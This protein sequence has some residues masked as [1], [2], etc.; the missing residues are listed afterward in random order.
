MKHFDPT[1]ESGKTYRTAGGHTM[2]VKIVIA[3][4]HRP[5]LCGQ[6]Q[7]V[8]GN[9]ATGSLVTILYN[10]D[11]TPKGTGWSAYQLLPGAIEDEKPTFEVGKSYRTRKGDVVKI[12]RLT[13]SVDYPL[14]GEHHNQSWTLD[15]RYW[16]DAKQECSADLMPGA[17]EDEPAVDPLCVLQAQINHIDLTLQNAMES[18]T[19]QANDLRRQLLNVRGSVSELTR[20]LTSARVNMADGLGQNDER[21]DNLEKHCEAMQTRIEDQ[22]KHQI[23]LYRH[24]GKLEV[25]AVCNPIINEDFEK[26]LDLV[27][28]FMRGPMSAQTTRVLEMQGRIANLEGM[29]A[30]TAATI[31]AAA[32]GKRDACIAAVDRA[33]AT[34]K[35]TIK[36][37]W[38]N[39]YEAHE[40]PYT[41][42][43]GPYT[44]REGADRAFSDRPRIAC[45]QIPDIT[46]GEGL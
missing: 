17:I 34:P 19:A 21:I 38:V 40:P 29:V 43:G 33:K 7:D 15:G 6:E 27:E 16:K 36:G 25:S 35:R 28:S 18:G 2:K 22:T 3:G 30:V 23:E 8:F 32:E 20:E 4:D 14:Q 44:S 1:F 26:R 45:I 37:G 31:N 39:V 9:R 10:K 24:L 46:E 12:E 11:G 42:I 5:D 13:K 41:W